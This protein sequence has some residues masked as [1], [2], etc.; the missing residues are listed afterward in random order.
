MH[1][2]V[3]KTDNTLP[4]HP[5]S[6]ISEGLGDEIS[7]TK[8]I[9]N[10]KKLC[11]ARNLGNPQET[12]INLIFRVGSRD[13]DDKSIAWRCRHGDENLPKFRQIFIHIGQHHKFK[14]EGA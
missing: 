2:S 10:P 3:C 4:F 11:L 8:G 14:D 13:K 1:H 7:V 12:L 6:S 9:E 5:A